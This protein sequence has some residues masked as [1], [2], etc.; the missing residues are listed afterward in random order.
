MNSKILKKNIFEGF[1]TVEFKSNTD[2]LIASCLLYDYIKRILVNEN[3][4]S[5]SMRLLVQ[6]YAPSYKNIIETFKSRFVSYVIMFR[7]IESYK[8]P[9]F[10]DFTDFEIRTIVDYYQ[11]RAEIVKFSTTYFSQ[12]MYKIVNM[13]KHQYDKLSE[14]HFSVMVPI[15]KYYM[16]NYQLSQTDLE[17]EDAEFYPSNPGKEIT[18][19]INGISPARVVS[20]IKSGNIS[21]NYYD[22]DI[23]QQYVKIVIK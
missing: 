17:V 9:V 19:G 20:D 8:K 15:I 13:K 2:K 23:Y 3:D 14:T 22:I 12:Y 10:T 16:D 5:N 18:F 1:R 21:I 7:T 4:V 6:S 11:N